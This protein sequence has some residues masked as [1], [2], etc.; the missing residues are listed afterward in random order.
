M[1]SDVTGLEQ[2]RNLG[3]GDRVAE[4]DVR[5]SLGACQ[6]DAP[7]LVAPLP[8]EQEVHLGA[9]LGGIDDVLD[10]V[11]DAVRPGKH[12]R[13]PVDVELLAQL[14]AVLVH[15][16][17]RELGAIGDDD[18]ETF[19]VDAQVAEVIAPVDDGD[20]PLS[21]G[22]DELLEL[23]E[24]L[25]DGAPL[26]QAAGGDQGVGPQVTHLGDVGASTQ[27]GCDHTG[28]WVEQ[29]GAGGVHQIGL[30]HACHGGRLSR[31][32]QPSDKAFHAVVVVLGN[33]DQGES[34]IV[35][36]QPL[37]GVVGEV[38]AD[39]VWRPA[40]HPAEDVGITGGADDPLGHGELV[41]DGDPAIGGHGR[42]FPAS[43]A[44][45]F[46][47]RFVRGGAPHRIGM[48]ATLATPSSGRFR[49]IGHEGF[50]GAG[51][52]LEVEMV[53]DG[54]GP[55]LTH[56]GTTLRIGQHLRQPSAGG[57][58]GL[59][60]DEH[61]GTPA[62]EHLLPGIE[63][64]GTERHP[65]G[66]VLEEFG[67]Q[68]AGVVGQWLEHHQTDLGRGDDLRHLGGPHHPVIGDDALTHSV[69]NGGPTRPLRSSSSQVQVDAWIVDVQSTRHLDH[70]GELALLGE[71][72]DVDQTSGHRLRI[73]GEVVLPRVVAHLH[74]AGMGI[75]VCDGVGCGDDGVG[76]T[77][78]QP[79]EDSSR[80]TG[81]R[82]SETIE[83]R[84]GVDLA[85][86]VLVG[87]VDDGA[88]TARL[89][90][91]GHRDEFGIVDLQDVGV[92]PLQHRPGLPLAAHQSSQASARV[93]GDDRHVVVDAVPVSANHQV[94]VVPGLYHRPSLLVEDPVVMGVVHGGQVDHGGVS[95][96]DHCFCSPWSCR[97]CS[98]RPVPPFRG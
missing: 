31:E 60:V 6:L 55:G 23:D 2:S 39:E 92:Q 19:G 4:L 9:T 10:A 13:H 82:A 18:H 16:E 30:A 71:V 14:L 74:G 35:G 89:E 27:P 22:V 80:T 38:R 8:D 96:L 69:L 47:T 88:A 5:D 50:E 64:R 79:G 29:V 12:S 43:G 52:R 11:L 44:A 40:G 49:E 86:E 68:G 36:V 98:R 75:R 28:H 77:I 97:G 42:S 53:G 59:G 46:F 67:G 51:L 45:T 21:L 93:Q 54:L 87:V 48:H 57:V 15:L 3:L 58:Q 65:G 37:F 20:D 84:L 7:V 76:M 83:V 81:H 32:E 78:S 56:P 91:Q 25:V 72:S 41:D 17:V 95:R 26:A 61:S 63:V 34:W 90:H 73:D 24:H 85:D 62:A 33:P 94:E 1:Q 70:E 66:H